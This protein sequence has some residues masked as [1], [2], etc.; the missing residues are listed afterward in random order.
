[1][2]G[3]ADF[4]G[5]VKGGASLFSVGQR[6]GPEFFEG[7]QNFFAHAKGG[8]RIFIA[9]AKGDQ[10]KLATRDHKQKPPPLPVKNDSSLKGKRRDPVDSQKMVIMYSGMANK[11]SLGPDEAF[12]KQRI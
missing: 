3:G 4:L 7:Y 9:H 6:G 10:K 8:T 1:M 2:G 11:S 12:C 5:V